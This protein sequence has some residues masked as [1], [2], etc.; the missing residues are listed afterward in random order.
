M[1]LSRQSDSLVMNRSAVRIRP[2]A[3]HSRKASYATPRKFLRGVCVCAC[4]CV[5]A[6]GKCETFTCSAFSRSA[7]KLSAAHS[8]PFCD[9]GG[10]RRLFRARHHEQHP[11]K[12]LRGCLR[13]CPTENT[14]G[15]DPVC[16]CG[17]VNASQK[18]GRSPRFAFLRVTPKLSRCSLIFA[19]RNQRVFLYA[20]GGFLPDADASP[21]WECCLPPFCGLRRTQT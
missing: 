13:L 1:W 16:A 10:S 15:G 11:R 2:P 7:R 20:V 14:F 9:V 21:T 17:C 12:D 6:K 5:P 4:G 3:P 8:F 18:C 19:P